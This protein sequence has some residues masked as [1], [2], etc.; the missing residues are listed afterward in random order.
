MGVVAE[1]LRTHPKAL[2]STHPILSFAGINAQR[3]LDSQ[4]IKEPLLPIQ[5]LVDG[6][7]WVLLLGLGHTVNSSIHYAEQLSGRKQ[8]VRWALTP[9][10]VIPCQ[11]FPGCSEGFD[12]IA[13]HLEEVVHK[14]ELGGAIVQAVPLVSLVDA[15]CGLLKE[16]PLALLCSREDCERCNAVR[17]S[18]ALN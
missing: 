4:S 11:R 6:E 12:E 15:A 3:V 5:T 16:D 14:V 1:A 18:V 8:F 13:S 9:K 17:E 7:G 2:R 10:G